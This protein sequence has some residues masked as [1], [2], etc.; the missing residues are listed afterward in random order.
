MYTYGKI[1]GQLIPVALSSVDWV[2]S[3]LYAN[4]IIDVYQLL[5]AIGSY[6]NMPGL[7]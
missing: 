5:Y 6:R 4:S 1:R 7:I 2:Y 3:S